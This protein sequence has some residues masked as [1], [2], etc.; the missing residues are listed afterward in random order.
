MR[1]LRAAVVLLAVL[2]LAAY[3]FAKFTSDSGLVASTPGFGK[4]LSNVAVSTST[5]IRL[6]PDSTKVAFVESGVVT[7]VRSRDGARVM[8]AGENIVDVAWMPDGKRVIVVEGPIPTGEIA[9]IDM[10]GKSAGLAKL[11]TSIGFGDGFGLAVDSRGTQAAAI[12]V[13]RDPIGG[14]IHTDLAVVDLQTGAVN[15]FESTTEESNP[16]FVD[17]ENVAYLADSVLFQRDLGDGRLTKVDQGFADGP[18]VA[19]PDGELALWTDEVVPALVG[20]DTT[21]RKRRTLR[22]LR[23][24]HVPVDVDAHLTRALVR[25][26]DADGTVHLSFDPLT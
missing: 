25:V 10:N 6:S 1:I 2:L 20:V 3:A 19:G 21:S 13:S 16:S 18:F 7:I 4:G 17:D 9:A 11:K 12:A 14:A 22:A 23:K 26:T 5:K 8:A 15:V 24:G